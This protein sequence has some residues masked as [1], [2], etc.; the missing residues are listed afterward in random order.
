MDGIDLSKVPQGVSLSARQKAYVDEV[1]D[2]EGGIPC[3]RKSRIQLVAGFMLSYRLYG[4]AK[5]P[6]SVIG[7]YQAL[8]GSPYPPSYA[9]FS[10][11]E[12]VYIQDLHLQI[13]HRG[14]YVMLRRVTPT[15][16]MTAAM[17]IGED[18]KGDA[19][20]LQIWHQEDNE[21]SKGT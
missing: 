11:L 9:P 15:L 8:C 12:K 16:H 13:H 7:I 18:E 17:A 6:E 19:V 4:G 20:L 3:D 21:R 2:H 10:S 1:E 14:K 5:R